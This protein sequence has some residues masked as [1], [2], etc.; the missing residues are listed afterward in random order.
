MS[1]SERFETK[2]LRVAKPS[3]G[4]RRKQPCVRQVDRV[5]WRSS[6]C[7][8]D[9]RESLIVLTIAEMSQTFLEIRHTVIGGSQRTEGMGHRFPSSGTE[10]RFGE[11]ERMLHGRIATGNRSKVPSLAAPSS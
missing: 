7:T 6:Q 5:V 9:I 2:S 8:S 3:V 11:N 1:Q 10:C 4:K